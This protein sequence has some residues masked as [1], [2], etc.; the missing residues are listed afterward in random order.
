MRVYCVYVHAPPQT[1]IT[2]T[3]AHARM[4]A[5]DILYISEVRRT[6]AC[7]FAEISHIINVFL[8]NYNKMRINQDMAAYK[9]HKCVCVSMCMWYICIL[10]VCCKSLSAVCAVF[11]VHHN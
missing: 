7:V 3:H 10:Y 11:N 1:R 5:H 9:S 2:H 4:Y 6:S 8:C